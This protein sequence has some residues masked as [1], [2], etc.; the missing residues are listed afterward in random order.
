[1]GP[2]QRECPQSQTNGDEAGAHPIRTGLV[3]G[4]ANAGESEISPLLDGRRQPGERDL[5]AGSARA[6]RALSDGEGVSRGESG[7]LPDG[8]L[9][10]LDAGQAPLRRGC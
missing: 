1:M 8:A 3:D 2:G 5:P 6:F 7:S 4:E 10:R 9:I